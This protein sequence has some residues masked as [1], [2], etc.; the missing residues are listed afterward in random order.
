MSRTCAR[1][2]AVSPLF[3]PHPPSALVQVRTEKLCEHDLLYQESNLELSQFGNLEEEV[4]CH[5]EETVCYP[6]SLSPYT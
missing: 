2:R 3:P 4:V 6:A 5:S 1:S